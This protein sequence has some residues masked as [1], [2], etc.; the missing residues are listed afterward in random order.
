MDDLV[1]KKIVLEV[2][3]QLNKT[4]I[5]SVF[6]LSD[7]NSFC[8]K[9]ELENM[10]YK[11]DI[12][13]NACDFN[14]HCMFIIDDL[15]AEIIS[16]ISNLL[17][18]DSNTSFIINAL[19]S[20]KKVLALKDN[21][22]FDNYKKTASNQLFSKLLELENTA[23]SYGLIILDSKSFLSYFSKNSNNEIKSSSASFDFTDK[24][25]ITKSDIMDIVKDYSS[26]IVRNNVIITPLVMDYIKENKINIIYNE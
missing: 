26:I 3:N 22:K 21:D 7:N 15:S 13:N 12:S 20:G 16:S 1:L 5:D 17:Y 4:C 24:K 9:N 2:I 25:V 8:F 19:L 18:K 23:K 11:V 6:V 14:N 10:G